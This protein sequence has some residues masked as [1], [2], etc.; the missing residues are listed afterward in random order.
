MYTPSD[1][2]VKYDD[3]LRVRSPLNINK[4]VF[5]KVKNVDLMSDPYT[6]G[7]TI[8]DEAGW[9]LKFQTITDRDIIKNF[10]CISINQMKE[11]YPEWI[12]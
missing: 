1:H 11:D 2:Y 4:F 9:N 3:L 10:G 7:V 6:Y 8:R 12:I 5:A